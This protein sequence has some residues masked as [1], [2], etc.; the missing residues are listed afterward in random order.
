MEDKS[1]NFRNTV[2]TLS[3]IILMVTWNTHLS[4]M[5]APYGQ[6]NPGTG[7]ST[8]TQLPIIKDIKKL[9]QANELKGLMALPSSLKAEIIN[10]IPLTPETVVPLITFAATIDSAH[11]AVM[12]LWADKITT[13]MVDN[14]PAIIALHPNIAQLI[15]TPKTILIGAMFEHKLL[16][17]KK[18]TGFITDKIYQGFT[19]P[20]SSALFLNDTTIALGSS[21]GTIQIIDTVNN[22][23]RTIADVGHVYAM[24]AYNPTIIVVSCSRDNNLHFYNTATGQHLGHISSA[25]SHVVAG[26]MHGHTKKINAIAVIHSNRIV[27]AGEDGRIMVWDNPITAG[28]PIIR[29][30]KVNRPEDFPI[31]GI[32]VLNN[33]HVIACSPL[34]NKVYLFNFATGNISNTPPNFSG[35]RSLTSVGPSDW[36]F[37]MDNGKIV[38]FNSNSGAV[39]EFTG[40]TGPIC[41]LS[42]LNNERF[43]SGS[44]DGTIRL[45]NAQTGYNIMT[46]KPN[47]GAINAI[48]TRLAGIQGLIIT[49]ANNGTAQ[50][51]KLHLS[52][53]LQWIAKEIGNEKVLQ[54]QIEK[55]RL[56]ALI[57]N[58]AIQCGIDYIIT[59]EREKRSPQKDLSLKSK[60]VPLTVEQA[61]QLIK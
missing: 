48:D 55:T 36:V 28:G 2:L 20:V 9:N 16:E 23:T 43:L 61:L 24:A 22:S 60:D 35:V 21:D 46:L 39:R 27:T 57:P 44:S 7:S 33:D 32:R 4:G 25:P 34:D 10:E 54:K 41:A 11:A 45:W 1:M 18:Q 31:T 30:F 37:G 40:H 53:F 49:G 13:Y 26:S 50:L 12:K 5:E 29:T 47:A 58:H 14:L 3:A 15:Q 52:E 6:E 19:Q 8:P 59:L 17:S 56:L 38:T 42:A 51:W